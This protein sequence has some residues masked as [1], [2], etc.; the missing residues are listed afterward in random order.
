MKPDV[1]VVRIATEQHSHHSTL[2]A[3][4]FRAYRINGHMWT[5]VTASH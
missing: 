1:K 5:S 2:T 4:F 3:R